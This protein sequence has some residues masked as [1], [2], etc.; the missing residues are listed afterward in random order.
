MMVAGWLKAKPIKGLSS[1]DGAKL[2][3]W[4]FYGRCRRRIPKP[5]E[6]AARLQAVIEI[7]RKLRTADNQPLFK[8]GKTGTEA[9][10]HME[11][12]AP[13]LRSGLHSPGP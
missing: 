13:P 7:G 8:A 10:Q 3:R 1:H 5:S 12:G 4:F 11:M 9:T 2:P 6:L